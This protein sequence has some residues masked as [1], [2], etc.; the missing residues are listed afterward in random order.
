MCK[1]WQAS[2]TL[3][4]EWNSQERTVCSINILRDAKAQLEGKK[5]Q[6]F[7]LEI[8]PA[9]SCGKKKTSTVYIF[10]PKSELCPQN[11]RKCSSAKNKTRKFYA[12]S[13]ESRALCP[14]TV[15]QN[16]KEGALFYLAVAGEVYR[17]EVFELKEDGVPTVVQRKRI[18]LG[19]TRLRV[20]DTA[21]ILH[22]C[23]CGWQL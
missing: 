21:W 19:T 12:D 20:A 5:L 23:G 16:R 17:A 2:L 1:S 15:L 4:K 13:E 9:P 7:Q 14:Y 6:S 10:L 3:C 8:L 18:Q 11:C 22:C